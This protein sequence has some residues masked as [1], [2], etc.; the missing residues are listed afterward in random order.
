MNALDS[1]IKVYE[2]NLFQTFIP[3][4][5][6]ETRNIMLNIGSKAPAF[7]GVNQHG[8][9]IS[10]SKLKGKKVVLYFYPRDATPTCTVEA[11]NLR[12]GYS[13]LTEYGFEV[14][15]VSADEVKSHTKFAEKHSLPFSLLA[16]TN[17]EIIKAYGVWGEKSLYGKKYMGIFR[18]TFVIDEKGKLEVIIEKVDSKNHTQQILDHYAV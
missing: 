7:K 18:K 11:C 17:Q 5:H 1:T 2:L 10:L 12:D 9:T 13:K 14:I 15:G 8:E 3:T 4:L 16:D 6:F